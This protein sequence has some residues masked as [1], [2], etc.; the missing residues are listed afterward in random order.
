MKMGLSA[1]RE[2]GHMVIMHIKRFLVMYLPHSDQKFSALNN[3][4]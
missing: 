3:E 1:I 2:N 4:L